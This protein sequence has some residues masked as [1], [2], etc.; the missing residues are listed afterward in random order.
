MIEQKLNTSKSLQQ[1]FSH[2]YKDFFATNDIVLS[3]QAMIYMTPGMAWRV[4]APIVGQ[5]I[6]FRF[7]VGVKENPHDSSLT[8]Q[9]DLTFYSEH[10]EFNPT[11]YNTM[12]MSKALPLLKQ[13]LEQKLNRTIPGLTFSLLSEA[14]ES[15]WLDSGVP[16]LMVASCYL[17]FGLITH[18]DLETLS[19]L[20]SKE[21]QDCETRLA[22]LFHEI[23][24]HS[25]RLRIL[26]QGGSTS[27]ASD[28]ISTFE[29]DFPIAY[30]TEERAGT[31]EKPVL[32]LPPLEGFNNLNEPHFHVWGHRLN[33]LAEV[34]GPFPLDVVSIYTGSDRQSGVATRYTTQEVIPRFDT[35]RDEVRKI[36]KHLHLND[37]HAPAFLKR[38]DVD[39][40]FWIRF[41]RGQMISRLQLLVSLIAV[42]SGRYETG[43]KLNFLGSLEALLH[44]NGPFEESPSKKMRGM[45]NTI[46]AKSDETG[47][48]VGMRVLRY[49]KS[50]GNII[51]YSGL[52]TFRKEI[53]EV[54]EKLQTEFGN[55]IHMDF[56]SWKDGWGSEGITVHQNLST[57]MKSPLYPD[58]EKQLVIWNN[59]VQEHGS[60]DQIENQELD[61]LLDATKGKIMVGG[62]K[63][64]AK[65]LPSQKGATEILTYLLTHFGKAVSNKDLPCQTYSSYRNELQGKIVG[66]LEK[67]IAERTDGSLGIKI[68]GDLTNFT[69]T[70]SPK[71]LKIGLLTER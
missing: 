27:G 58:G 54:V 11:L 65:N 24:G 26:C 1:R 22:K 70:F 40:L 69:V 68:Q 16:I 25:S 51:L 2:I 21:I 6:P 20:P 29:S 4:G 37:S 14:V 48:S 15:R 46:K 61:L 49:G 50:D 31:V 62:K 9:D 42:Y 10:N 34:N 5:K 36:F 7:Y 17:H 59:G 18:E 71:R 57:G 56:I 8:I 45:I 41:G 63:V 28:Y 19:T 32:E 64:T 3:C 44:A 47:I 35:L 60:T 33:E 66:P 53:V 13:I 55:E 30:F 43:A 23:H 67:V 38:I 52:Q 12:V 39:G